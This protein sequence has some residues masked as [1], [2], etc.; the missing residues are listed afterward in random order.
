MFILPTM[1]QHINVK[2]TIYRS[3]IDSQLWPDSFFPLY[4]LGQL[5]HNQSDYGKLFLYKPII[6]FD[7]KEKK[8]RINS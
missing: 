1:Y 8:N 3:V 7:L 5:Q 2:R 4:Q 6:Y